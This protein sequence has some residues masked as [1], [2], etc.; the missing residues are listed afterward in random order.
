[1][2]QTCQT[3]LAAFTQSVWPGVAWKFS[4]LTA[5]GCPIEFGFSTNSEALRYT[6]EVAGPECDH[7]LRLTAACSLIERLGR[8]PP[9]PA[10][11]QEWHRLQAAGELHWGA[12]LGVRCDERETLKL[13]VEMPPAAGA[14]FPG[15]LPGARLLMIGYELAS[16]RTE[17]Y[18]RKPQMCRG[19]F[20]RL[21]EYTR[22]P[23]KSGVL[24]TDF[25]ALCQMP[26]ESA[27]HWYSPA[28][29]IA[30]II[31]SNFAQL[32]VFLRAKAVG[33]PETIRQIFLSLETEMA[34]PKSLYRQ[35]L[36]SV[37]APELPDHGVIS[38]GYDPHGIK[39]IR[40][41][42]SGADLAALPIAASGTT[43]GPP[44]GKNTRAGSPAPR[45]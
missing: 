42:I 38:L 35:C 27:L 33:R 39:E 10:L 34:L 26:W 29:S 5:D 1:M 32:G 43:N 28:Y 4:G 30:Q 19:D 16:G 11:L 15:Q 6:V 13:Y 7:A 21:E 23:L 45:I 17:Y 36:A 31:G 20:Q 3:C 44:A 18:F 8:P 22:R 25:A 40:I 9:A 12:W 24:L 2:M 14:S 37:S 41:G